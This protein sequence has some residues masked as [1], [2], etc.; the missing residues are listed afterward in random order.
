M[1]SLS[2]TNFNIFCHIFKSLS[3]FIYICTH[4]CVC[5]MNHLKTSC[6]HC[7]SSALDP[8]GMQNGPGGH[9]A[10][11]WFVSQ[12]RDSKLRKPQSDGLR[13]DV[14]NLCSLLQRYLYDLY[15]SGR[16][17]NL[18]SVSEATLSLSS[19]AVCYTNLLEKIV[20]NKSYQCLPL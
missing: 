13:A 2:F 3:I 18:S 1:P 7:N 4:I 15:Y 20:Q 6:R 11:R 5:F 8:R 10:Y 14:P 17:T 19:K 16:R 12:L 9:C